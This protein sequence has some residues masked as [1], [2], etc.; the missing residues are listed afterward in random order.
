[1][2]EAY[3]TYRE[4]RIAENKKRRLRI[5]RRQRIT[6]AVIIA[7]ITVLATLFTVSL[8]I[9]AR[10]EAVKY[11]YYTSV[12]VHSGDTLESM[13]AGYIT[14]EYKTSA[15]YIREVCDINNMNDGD[16]ILAGEYII[17]PYYSEE[18]KE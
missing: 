5:V 3:M 9:E 18:F 1:M 16:S 2:N 14:D 15:D 7:F 4:I 12:M 10:S 8:V 13:A 11:K 17:L 6:L